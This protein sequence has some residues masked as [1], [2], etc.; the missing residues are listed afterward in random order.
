MRT[1]LLGVTYFAML[2][3]APAGAAPEPPT[4]HI[5]RHFDTP[6]GER[7]PDLLP[8]GDAR[9]AALVAWFEGKALCAI[10]VSDYKRAR[11]TAAPLAAARKIAVQTY[12]PTDTPAVVVRA[13][14]LTCPVLIVGHSN[15]VPDIIA[16]LGGTSPGNLKHEDFGDIWTFRT[17]RMTHDRIEP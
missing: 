11:Q 15:T 8:Q 4:I 2:G 3:A 17:E 6:A 13:R 9:A 14:A 5:V 10:L 12:D 7:D 16:K 1:L